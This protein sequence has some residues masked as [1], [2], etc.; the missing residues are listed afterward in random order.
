MDAFLFFLTREPGSVETENPGSAKCGFG[1][2]KSLKK[3]ENFRAQI[4]VNANLR[5]LQF[6]PFII[7]FFP[8]YSPFKIVSDNNFC[9]VELYFPE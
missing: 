4:V 6:K 9:K 8:G 5:S 7:Q 3:P 2:G 1:I